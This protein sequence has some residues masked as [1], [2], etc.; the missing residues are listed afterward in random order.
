LTLAV[1]CGGFRGREFYLERDQQR[2]IPAFSP[3][4][5]Q[6]IELAHDLAA[7]PHTLWRSARNGLST[8]RIRVKRRLSICCH[9]LAVGF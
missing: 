3:I 4:A 7:K 8:L 9:R 2:W 6:N 5:L 1:F